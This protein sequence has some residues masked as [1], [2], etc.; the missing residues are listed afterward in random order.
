M[1]F[2]VGAYFGK[3]PDEAGKYRIA[4]LLPL[5][6]RILKEKWDASVAHTQEVEFGVGRAIAQAF[7]AKKVHLPELPT[8]EKMLR[9][10]L[11]SEARMPEWMRKFEEANNRQ[12]E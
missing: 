9:S 3:F 7:S 12:S 5:Y 2:T 1:L 10:K 11:P 4:E 6:R 8:F